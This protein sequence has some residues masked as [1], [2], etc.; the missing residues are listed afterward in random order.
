MSLALFRR[1][2]VGLIIYITLIPLVSETLLLIDVRL[3]KKIVFYLEI[4]K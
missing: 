1:Q 4:L 3:G 2:K